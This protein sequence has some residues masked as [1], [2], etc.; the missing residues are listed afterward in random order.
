MKRPDNTLTLTSTQAN[1]HQ[2]QIKV[3]LLRIS[4][5]MFEDNCIIQAETI[6]FRISAR[7]KGSSIRISAGGG[8]KDTI[9]FALLGTTGW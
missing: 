4:V 2:K 5:A 7:R 9:T 6:D 1:M 3:Q 8:T